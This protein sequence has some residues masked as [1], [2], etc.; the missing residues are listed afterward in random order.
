MPGSVFRV[1]TLNTLFRPEARTRLA[2]VAPLINRSGIELVCLQEVPY[3]VNASFLSR[4]L[5]A[6]EPPAARRFGLWCV[7]GLVTFARAPILR[8]SYEVF[9]R[10]GD[11]LSIGAAD[12]LLRKG[13]LTTHVRVGD[14]DVVM[15]NT[16]LL[17]NYDQDWSPANRYAIHE[18]SELEQL[19]RAAR[20]AD[21]SA[22]LMV[23]GDFNVPN[24]S[25]IFQRFLAGSGLLSAFGA[26][27]APSTLRLD[28]ANQSPLAIDNIL[29]R[30]P[31]GRAAEVSVT[32]MFEAP[33]QLAPGRMGFV[34][35]HL[36]LC[37]TF[38]LE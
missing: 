33:I 2:A 12:R 9:D 32:P 1:L 6:Y 30:A 18:E 19:A 22:M 17:A 38:R 34:S 37:A 14:L 21:P 8:A 27:T 29:Y 4:L 11:W 28:A 10:R 24:D 35:D 7:G 36:A 3:R 25:P 5:T 31:A 23:A 20:S 16:H 15:I 26:A 13:F